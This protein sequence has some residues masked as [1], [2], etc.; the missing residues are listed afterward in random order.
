M[1]FCLR[2][3]FVHGSEV[4]FSFGIRSFTSVREKK[5]RQSREIE[6]VSF[7]LFPWFAIVSSFFYPFDVV[8]SFLS[9][10]DVAA[11]PVVFL[12]VFEAVASFISW[13]ITK[14]SFLNMLTASGLKVREV[15]RKMAWRR[16]STLRKK[17][18][19]FTDGCYWATGFSSW[20]RLD[21]D[22]GHAWPHWSQLHQANDDGN[23]CVAIHHW[24]PEDK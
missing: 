14:K 7:S 24:L 4:L 15:I 9:S 11:S 18:E 6:I 19:S 1:I 12:S 22:D 23:R 3:V 17:I 20:V 8:A 5:K 13:E 21:G 16:V 10:F 2:I